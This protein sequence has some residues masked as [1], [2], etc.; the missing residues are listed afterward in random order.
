MPNLN[1]TWLKAIVMIV[2]L[3][4]VNLIGLWFFDLGSAGFLLITGLLSF[5]L[6]DDT[7]TDEFRSFVGLAVIISTIVWFCAVGSWQLDNFLAKIIFLII[8]LFIFL[9]SGIGLLM[10]KLIVF[11]QKKFIHG[12]K[13]L[14]SV[15]Q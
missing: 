14:K 11:L 6:W 13:I 7:H 2:G 15:S 3:T 1:N 10:G 12:Q 4:T 5:V 9:C 8:S